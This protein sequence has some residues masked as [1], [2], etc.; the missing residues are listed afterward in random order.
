MSHFLFPL[1]LALS[2]SFFLAQGL[3][4]SGYG[5]KDLES[6]D[7]VAFQKEADWWNLTLSV[8]GT[9]ISK[10]RSSE[11]WLLG[12]PYTL[13]KVS[14]ST[15]GLSFD[16]AFTN[17]PPHSFVGVSAVFWFFDDQWGAADFPEIEFDAGYFDL[18]I[19]GPR[20][21]QADFMIEDGGL[22][23][24]NDFGHDHMKF[25][26]I[27]NSSSLTFRVRSAALGTA[28]TQAFGFRELHIHLSNYSASVIPDLCHISEEKSPL[29]YSQCEC[30]L[31]QAKDSNGNCV[32]CAANCDICFGP[33][34]NQCLACS[35]GTYWDGEKCN[36][37]HLACQTCTG[38]SASQCSTCKYGFYHYE[39]DTCSDI[40]EIP[41]APVQIGID[42]YCNPM[43][44]S[45][46]F[47]WSLNK[48]CLA[49]CD[50]PLVH[51]L[52]ENRMEA[53][54]SPCSNSNKYLYANSSCLDTCKPPLLMK[55]ENLIRYCINPCLGA[56]YLYPNRSCL[57]DCPWPLISRVEPDVKYCWNPCPFVGQ[58]LYN[59]G[60]CLSTC[61]A[62]LV[63]RS[64]SGVKYCFTPCDSVGDYI[65]DNR[66]CSDT[67]SS[68]LISRTEPMVA[69]Y[70]LSPCPLASYFL[71]PNGSC[72]TDCMLPLL[73]KT[74][75]GVKFCYSPCSISSDYIY[76]N[77][78]CRTTCPYPLMSQVGSS[79][80]KYCFNPCST[81][82][83]LYSDRSCHDS[84][85]SPLI[86]RFEPGVN[87]CNTPCSNINEYV[88]SDGVCSS[89]CEYPYKA[90]KNSGF[91]VC[92][93][94]I[95]EIQIHQAHSL[96]IATDIANT[97]CGIGGILTGFVTPGD[98]TS[99]LMWSL[100]KMLQFTKFIDV[101]FP[102]QMTVV[103]VKQNDYYTN[104][105]GYMSSI[106][107]GGEDQKR[108]LSH[109][110]TLGRFSYYDIPLR[111][112]ENYWQQLIV[113][114]TLIMMLMICLIL[115]K[116]LKDPRKIKIVKHI[117]EALQWNVLLMFFC[118]SYGDLVLYSALEFQTVSFDSFGST[119]SFAICLL[120]V[121]LAIFIA[122]KT[123]YIIWKI[124]KVG[125]DQLAVRQKRAVGEKWTS[126]RTFFE[127]YKSE[128]AAQQMF[129]LIYLMRVMLFNVVLGYIFKSPLAQAVLVMLINLMMVTYLLL[130]NPFKDKL[131]FVQH[132]TLESMLLVYNIC[133]LILVT[134]DLVESQ[135]EG[136]RAFFGGIMVVMLITG[137]I[138][139]AILIVFKLIFRLKEVYYK[140][141]A[142][143]EAA[144][145]AGPAMP[146]KKI[147]ARGNFIIEN[148]QGRLG[149]NHIIQELDESQLMTIP[150]NKSID[151]SK[152]LNLAPQTFENQFN[153]AMKINLENKTESSVV[154]VYTK[155][156]SHFKR[157]RVNLFR[158]KA[159]IFDDEL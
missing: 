9:K 35:A 64:E 79:D 148:S 138:A 60:S 55:T 82:R 4:I 15:Y 142:Q 33:D 105:N 139:S 21:S 94:N 159:T 27:H 153:N 46:Q 114:A 5:I 98:P 141:K 89:V 109:S 154:E 122:I 150:P 73:S 107:R 23:Q 125:G 56:D 158:D 72:L 13:G 17:L 39:N 69:K 37:C 104:D 67:C 11:K 106:N 20:L 100:L 133:L 31:N 126:H 147:R 120:M 54:Y 80:F 130:K 151:L 155:K 113:F 103:F 43:C 44:N 63:S 41:F 62:P 116:F 96:A 76:S 117:R 83:F 132:L 34:N 84:C 53:C 47:Y 36:T 127:M 90:L 58:F 24:K 32:N 48:T 71:Y 6:N 8:N 50:P 92:S 137:P 134:M 45:S 1:F 88:Y 19:K 18:D 74:E 30:A 61:P 131:C 144:E 136:T 111:F 157:R 59:N 87:Y 128:S 52:D 145:L 40:C 143:K 3:T 16:R 95:N 28:S 110:K 65:Y 149:Q 78:S 85:E 118:G 123:L 29:Q 156:Q 119:I 75:R 81:S 112:L 129:L 102:A 12:G 146:F 115:L 91:K 7:Q 26:F 86:A 77:G 152:E 38:P 2:S 124:R 49:S 93:M 99:M 135:A 25:T 108:M 140:S 10:T 42:K 68:P 70:C 14:E 66:S 57:A 101:N 121:I 22:A 97:V 51:S